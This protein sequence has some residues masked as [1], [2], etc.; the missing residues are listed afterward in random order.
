M[1]KLLHGV[2]VFLPM[3]VGS[4]EIAFCIGLFQDIVDSASEYLF[5]RIPPQQSHKVG[6]DEL[7][8]RVLHE[9]KHGHH[10][11]NLDALHD[12][13]LSLG[14]RNAIL[15]ERLDDSLAS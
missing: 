5:G 7:V 12:G 2:E 1:E 4:I 9:L 10:Q 15:A 13:I 3:V 6:K 14:N 11:L 8:A